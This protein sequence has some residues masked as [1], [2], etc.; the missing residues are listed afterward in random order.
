L[1]DVAT[2]DPLRSGGLERRKKKSETRCVIMTGRPSITLDL[3]MSETM[4]RSKEGILKIKKGSHAS[5]R[6]LKKPNLG[7]DQKTF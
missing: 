5:R 2:I 6:G 7:K 1:E 4:Q 3:E